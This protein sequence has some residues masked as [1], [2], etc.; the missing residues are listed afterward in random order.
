M[1]SQQEL[2]NDYMDLQ[3]EFS[4]LED[5]YK[6]LYEEVENAKKSKTFGAVFFFEDNSSQFIPFMQD[7]RGIM[8]HG[9]RPI[10]FKLNFHY[11]HFIEWLN[12][13][14]HALKQPYDVDIGTVERIALDGRPLR[15][16]K[17]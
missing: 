12:Q 8:K 1:R 14:K 15:I 4:D 11:E 2:L 5:R 10:D 6:K 9:N 3:K 13:C 16:T 7:V 17:D